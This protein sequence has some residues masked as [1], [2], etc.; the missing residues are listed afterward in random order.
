VGGW[1][2]LIEDIK[3]GRC[4]SNRPIDLVDRWVAQRVLALNC[5]CF[6]PQGRGERNDGTRQ[7]GSRDLSRHAACYFAS[8]ALLAIPDN[9]GRFTVLL[10]PVPTELV[11][12]ARRAEAACPERAITVT[13]A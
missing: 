7:R 2:R 10:D 11:E 9:D 3:S 13:E 1:S 5:S 6:C 8:Q 4:R 12:A